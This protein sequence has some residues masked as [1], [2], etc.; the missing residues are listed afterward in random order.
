MREEY[1]NSRGYLGS[2]IECLRG[3]KGPAGVQEL[4]QHRASKVKL[5]LCEGEAHRKASA[6]NSL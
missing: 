4:N 6:V 3:Q 2:I 1:S 5:V